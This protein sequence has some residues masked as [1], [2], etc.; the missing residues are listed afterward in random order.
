MVIAAR[1]SNVDAGLTMIVPDWDGTPRVQ[2]SA[3]NGATTVFRHDPYGKPRGSATTGWVGDSGFAGGTKDASGLTLLGARY[4]D[5]AMG[6]F[7][8]PD[9]VLDRMNPRMLDAYGYG[10]ASPVT[11]S[12]RTG[13]KPLADGNFEFKG[14]NSSGWDLY[15]KPVGNQPAVLVVPKPTPKPV[16]T[17]A[18]APTYFPIPSSAPGSSLQNNPAPLPPPPSLQAAPSNVVYRENPPM[19]LAHVLEIS[20]YGV[21]QATTLAAGDLALATELVTGGQCYWDDAHSLNVCY[22]GNMV[23]AR[24]G[25]TYGHTFISTE[26][27][28]RSLLGPAVYDRLLNHESR[29]T[30]QWEAAGPF[31]PIAYA[32]QELGAAERLALGLG[33][34]NET[35]CYNFFEIS[36]G[37]AD[38]GYR[39]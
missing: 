23:A 8:S 34:V 27:D 19:D 24:G 25:T 33:L 28:P 37:L 11:F 22:G 15:T 17:P 7:L 29:H 14:S 26:G 31:F 10:Y 38:G 32:Q 30:K 21:N 16:T 18:P 36:A 2:V 9:P 5:P 6:D 35:A 39:C 12:D 1:T 13:L 4:Y 3:A 20:A